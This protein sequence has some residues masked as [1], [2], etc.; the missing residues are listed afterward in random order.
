[1]SYSLRITVTGGQPAI[2][3]AGGQISDGKFLLSGHE[4]PE[5]VRVQLTRLDAE[6]R[7]LVTV[8][9]GACR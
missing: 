8:S 5:N 9:A 1:M 6:G 2:E 3:A 7:S 4:D